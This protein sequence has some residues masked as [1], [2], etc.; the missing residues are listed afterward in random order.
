MSDPV[1]RALRDHVLADEPPLRMNLD[2]VLRA[3]RRSLRY[4]RAAYSGGAAAL[5]GALALAIF[6]NGLL[7]TGRTAADAPSVHVPN[8][9]DCFKA[10]YAGAPTA[11]GPDAFPPPSPSAQD[12]ADRISCYLPGAVAAALPGAT[13]SDNPVRRT[14]ALIAVP[15]ADGSFSATAAVSTSDG[16]GLI[17]FSVGRTSPQDPGVWRAHCEGDSAK[18]TCR[19]G[20]H[21]EMVEVYDFG[22][23]ARGVRGLTIYLYSGHTFVLAGAHNAL[24]AQDAPPTMPEPPLSVDQLIAIASDPALVVFP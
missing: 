7:P 20:P 9:Y 1:T 18:A 23:D 16:T 15:E 10:I 4:R 21:G 11:A 6:G 8:A 17:I 2:S 3:G 22:A 12:L 5:T 24:E 14:P 19:T 13:V